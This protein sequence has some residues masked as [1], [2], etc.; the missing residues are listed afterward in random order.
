MTRFKQLSLRLGLLIGTVIGLY[1]FAESQTQGFRYYHLISNL[2]NEPRWE[3][4]P[5]S[6]QEMA[7]I[8]E[9]LKQPFTFLGA[10]GWCYAFIGQDQKT[11]IKFFKHS[12]LY[13]KNILRDFS[14]C[15]LLSK[16]PPDNYKPY[17]FHPFNFISCTLLYSRI[18][19]LSGIQYLHLNKTQ[20]LHP[21]ATLYDNLGIRYTIDLNETEFVVQ[22]KAELIFPHIHKLAKK[23]NMIGAQAAIDNMLACILTI[24]Q[25]GIRD[26]DHALRNN[27]GFI[28]ERAVTI[29]LSS[30]VPDESI[31]LPGNY[32]K[33]L[34]VKTRRLSRWLNKYHPKLYDYLENRLSDIIENTPLNYDNDRNLL[35]QQPP[36]RNPI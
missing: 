14:F 29:D 27:F 33:E 6:D 15:K 20:G 1:Y 28:G 4:P 32:K 16:S 7:R 25:Q 22:E 31:K 36:Q 30:W 9:L 26:A 21:T 34:V 18:K 11:V 19:E 13:P 17:Y 12:H 24:Y 8:N 2:P 23:N 10:G 3:V 5:L 35:H